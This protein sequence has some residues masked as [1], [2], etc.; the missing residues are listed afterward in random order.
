MEKNN[1]TKK[2]II[3]VFATILLIGLGA[4]GMYF[5]ITSIPGTLKINIDT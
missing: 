5:Y 1:N 3:A 2:I 4:F